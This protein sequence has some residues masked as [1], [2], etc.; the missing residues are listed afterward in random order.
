MALSS[1]P[2]GNTFFASRGRERSPP[3]R[4]T[5]YGPNRPQRFRTLELPYFFLHVHFSDGLLQPTHTPFL[6][7]TPQ[8]LHGLHPQVWHIE[9]SLIQGGCKLE[10][11]TSPCSGR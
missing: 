11:V 4:P 5:S 3:F 8:V 6:I 2:S 10:H 1:L 9:T 7:A